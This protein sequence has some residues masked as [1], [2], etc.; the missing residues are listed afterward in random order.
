MERYRS[1]VTGLLYGA[2][3][4]ILAQLAEA[5]AVL[6]VAGGLSYLFFRFLAA[7]RLLR[8]LPTDELKGL[9]MPER[10]A[11][12]HTTVD[13]RMA[14]GRLAGQLPRVRVK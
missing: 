5:G 12:G 9:D 2:S 7:L 11:L 4:Q 13:V 14:G 3:R 6:V 8:R 10:G 1:P